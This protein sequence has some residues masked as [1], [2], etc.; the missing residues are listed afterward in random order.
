[1][2]DSE[3][4][5][6]VNSAKEEILK[7]AYLAIVQKMIDEAFKGN[8]QVA[9]FLYPDMP[10]KSVQAAEDFWTISNKDD[11]EDWKCEKCRI[12]EISG[13]DGSSG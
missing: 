5:E 7:S 8:F 2:V 1:M 10:M 13:E 3:N 9:K 4:I 6:D 12:S 11:D